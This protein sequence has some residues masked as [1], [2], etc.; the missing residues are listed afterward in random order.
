MN[1][2]PGSANVATEARAWAQ[3]LK[4]SSKLIADSGIP[5]IIINQVRT[6][7]GAMFGNPEYYPG[8]SALKF[9]PSIVIRMSGAKK[10]DSSKTVSTN[11]RMEKNKVGKPFKKD[12]IKI[13][14]GEGIDNSSYL[15]KH[16]SCLSKHGPASYH[17]KKRVKTA[18]G[19]EERDEV[20]AKGAINFRKW[21]RDN[22]ERLHKRLII[23][24]KK[25]GDKV[26]DTVSGEE[27]E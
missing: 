23:E 22:R 4:K 6:N 26:D 21:C 15:L 14:Y 3:E 2:D 7:P 9:W 25:K 19:I 12:T 11:V 16:L 8:G 5:V 17:E 18:N 1:S 27:K 24:R 20:I 10:D 13:V